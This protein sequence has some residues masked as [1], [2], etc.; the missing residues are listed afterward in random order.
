M[1]QTRTPTATG[2][3]MLH[4]FRAVLTHHPPTSPIWQQLLT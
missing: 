4:A 2:N 1:Q 3:D